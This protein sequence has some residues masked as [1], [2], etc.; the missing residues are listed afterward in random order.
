VS[1][2]L[3]TALMAATVAGLIRAGA[4]GAPCTY[5]GCSA[6]HTGLGGWQVPPGAPA[7]EPHHH[8]TWTPEGV[9]REQAP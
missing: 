5:P 6:V 7:V 1:G 9:G 8:R 4:G 2:L 3:L